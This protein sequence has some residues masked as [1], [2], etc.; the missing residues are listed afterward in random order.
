MSQVITEPGFL[1]QSQELE[2]SLI[3]GQLSEFCEMKI[4]QETNEKERLLWQFLKVSVNL[5]VLTIEQVTFLM[6]LLL[7]FQI[8]QVE[9]FNLCRG[10]KNSCWC[11][12]I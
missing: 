1:Q 3:T 8:N 4:A 5:H 9:V 12:H 11:F 10:I 7:L 6:L 2:N